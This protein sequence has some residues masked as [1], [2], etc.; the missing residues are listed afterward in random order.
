MPQ[1]RPS[2]KFKSIRKKAESFDNRDAEYF[3]SSGLDYNGQAQTGFTANGGGLSGSVSIDPGK[4]L[5]MTAEVGVNAAVKRVKE[6]MLIVHR[7]PAQLPDFGDLDNTVTL[8]CLA[9]V[10]WEGSVGLSLD[11]GV[12]VTVSAGW[13]STGG[14]TKAEVSG[15]DDPEPTGDEKAAAD[16]EKTESLVEACCA[17]VEL[18]AGLSASVGYT[19]THFYAIDP[20]P[21]YF[22]SPQLEDGSMKEIYDTLDAILETG[23]TKGKLKLEACNFI[24]QYP[25]Y[26]GKAISYSNWHGGHISSQKVVTRLRAGLEV[27]RREMAGYSP[28]PRS[29]LR[30]VRSKTRNLINQLA[31]FAGEVEP[32]GLTYL[33]ISSHNPK[34]AAALQATAEASANAAGLVSASAGLNFTALGISGGAKIAYVRFQHALFTDPPVLCTQDTRIVYKQFDLSALKISGEA[35]VGAL[36]HKVGS[37]DI[38]EGLKGFAEEGKRLLGTTLNRMTYD[39]VT[40]Y[41]ERPAPLA[42]AGKDEVEVPLLPGSGFSLGESC[43]LS[44]LHHLVTHYDPY[45]AEGDEIGTFTS[46]VALAYAQTIADSI[47]VP[48]AKFCQFLAT[49]EVFQIVSSLYH[50]GEIGVLLDGAVVRA[51]KTPEERREFLARAKG[52]LGRGAGDAKAWHN[53]SVLIESSFALPSGGV[54]LPCTR[55]RKVDKKGAAQDFFVLSTDARSEIPALP[56]YKDP[57][58]RARLLHAIRI[59]FRIQDLNNDDKTRFTLG[60]KVVGT[61]AKISLETVDRAGSEGIVDLCTVWMNEELKKKGAIH[62]ADPYELS[63]P[64]VTL[65]CQ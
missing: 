6:T 60:F 16:R 26:F 10:Q 65:F 19:Y 48:L 55:E 63:V 34:G 42:R 61:G 59:R 50:Q 9:G 51:L 24:N 20:A 1:P 27:I 64:P 57:D 28:S 31:V 30:D 47:G 56:Q 21:L 37:G 32:D 18:K 13:G 22:L 8:N 11:V 43:V 29:H 3:L 54:T 2:A 39:S 41:W 33:R 25:N 5:G 4:I 38:N 58:S 49:P 17:K 52:A 62:P 7:G 45:M 14:K 46:E 53:K 15:Y 12:G 44:N 40:A 36:G 23:T 35:S